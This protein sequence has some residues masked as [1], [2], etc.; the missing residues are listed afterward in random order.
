MMFYTGKLNFGNPM[1][2][3]I[4]KISSVYAFEEDGTYLYE[5]TTSLMVNSK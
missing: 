5:S 1:L 2:T 3:V 4:K